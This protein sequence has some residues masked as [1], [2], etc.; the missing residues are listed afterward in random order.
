MRISTIP[1]RNALGIELP[2]KNRETVGLRELMS[3]K[4][5][6]KTKMKLPMILGKDIG[7][8]PQ[9]VDM[10]AMPH[11]LIAGTTGSGKSVA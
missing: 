6:E 7:G 8:E 9:V 3:S 5:F 10:A 2:N 11:L 1:E 4:A